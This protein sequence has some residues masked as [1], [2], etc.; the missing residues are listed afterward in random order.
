MAEAERTLNTPRDCACFNRSGFDRYDESTY[1]VTI[2][3]QSAFDEIKAL[4]QPIDK[5]SRKMASLSG[6]SHQATVEGALLIATS[7][8]AEK[9][10]T[11]LFMQHLSTPEPQHKFAIIIENLECFLHFQ[12]TFTFISKYCFHAS[13]SISFETN[14]F[15]TLPELHNIEFIYAAGNSITNRQIIPYLEQFEG[16][17]WCLLDIDFGG[18][19]IYQN[20]LNNGLSSDKTHFLIPN[21]IEARLLRSRRKAPQKTLQELNKFLNITPNINQLIRLIH[22]YQTIIEQESYRE[23]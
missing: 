8:M 1:L 10:Y 16:G 5:T 15:Q 20:L 3:N 9:P 19:Q 7:M 4:L 17:L 6:N 13:Q 12:E 2:T 11:H 21:D 22:H 18:L 23:R 14:Q